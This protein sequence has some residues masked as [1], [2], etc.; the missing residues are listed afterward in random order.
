MKWKTY[1]VR[2]IRKLLFSF[3][4]IISAVNLNKTD[5]FEDSNRSNLLYE[6][7]TS[8]KCSHTELLGIM[9]MENT[10]FK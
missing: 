10:C 3:G 9:G 5:S 4:S 8:L 6:S 7:H 1:W 2:G